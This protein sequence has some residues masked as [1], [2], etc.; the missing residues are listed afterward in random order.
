[1]SKQ[2]KLFLPLFLASAMWAQNGKDDMKAAGGHY[3]DATKYAGVGIVKGTKKGLI[4][5][6]NFFH[7]PKTEYHSKAK[8]STP[9]PSHKSAASHTVAASSHKSATPA[10]H[11]SA[12][13]KNTA[14]TVHHTNATGT[15]QKRSTATGKK[16]TAN[17]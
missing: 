11:S 10:T 5:T 2:L 12:V 6:K 7:E 3:K 8:K 15:T 17:N 9:A 14:A 1:M 16:S 13:H 4:A